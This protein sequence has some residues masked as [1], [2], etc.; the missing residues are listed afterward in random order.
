MRK[1]YLLL[2]TRP[3]QPGIVSVSTQDGAP[4]LERS[5]LRFA[6]C[7]D[8]IDAA[9]MHLHECLRRHLKTLEPRSYAVDLV[10]AVAAAD[11]V[12]LDHRRVFIEPALAQ[13]DRLDDRINRLHRRHRRFDQ[14]MQAIG[15]FA[16]LLLLLLGLIPL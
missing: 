5:G 14:L 7:F 15:L 12:E 2:E 3:D 8:D 4:Q 10:E 11:A 13:C 9:P 1:G 16:L 6:A